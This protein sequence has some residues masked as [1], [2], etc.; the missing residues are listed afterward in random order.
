MKRRA[1]VQTAG[2]AMALPSLAMAADAPAS[3]SAR[4]RLLAF[5]SGN[6]AAFLKHIVP[7][8]GKPNLKIC[9]VPTATGDSL[10][11]ITNW[12]A[13]SEGLPMQAH[14]MKSFVCGQP[15]HLEGLLIG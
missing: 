8:A 10:V 5:G 7:M 12:Y 13:A 11:N 9:Y 6:F 1:F 14:V 4:R 3:P 2:L 15:S